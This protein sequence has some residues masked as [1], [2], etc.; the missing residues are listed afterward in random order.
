MADDFTLLPYARP[1]LV[2]STRLGGAD[3]RLTLR[4]DAEVLADGQVDGSAVNL[5]AALKGPGDVVGF[6]SRAIS[7]SDPDARS[8]EFEANYLPY[9]EFAEVDFPWRYSLDK[10]ATGG[11]V[12]PWL[13]LIALKADE[14]EVLEPDDNAPLPAIRVGSATDSLPPLDQLV[15]TCHV[16][17]ARDEGETD[18]SALLASEPEQARAR[19][20]CV[21]N[22]EEAAVYT[23]FL[24]PSYE[25]GRQAGLGL[26]PTAT[27]P[28]LPAWERND[29][30]IDLPV[31]YSRRFV[32]NSGEDIEAMLR[33]LRSINSADAEGIGD[34]PRIFAGAPGHYDD[35]SHQTAGFLRQAA[36]QEPGTP[37]PGFD[38]DLRLVQRIDD[39][40]TEAIEGDVQDNG[41]DPLVTFPAYG[42]RYRHDTTLNSVNRTGYWFDHLNLDLK[43]RDAA[44]R[45]AIIVRR[46]QDR[47]MRLAWEQYEGIV[48]ANRRLARLQ[49]AQKLVERMSKRRLDHLETGTL[50]SLAEPLW[51][52]VQTNK[53]DTSLRKGITARGAPDSYVS[54][55]MRRLAAKRSRAPER[56]S[57]MRATP[58]P[59]LPG[60]VD[61]AEAARAS[62]T[63]AHRRAAPEPIRIDAQT[64]D[65]LSALMGRDY[66]SEKVTLTGAIAVGAVSSKSLASPVTSLLAVLPEAKAA[67]LV[68]GRTRQEARTIAPVFRAPDIAD[69]L[70]ERQVEQDPSALFAGLERLPD[71]TVTFFE[72]NRAFIEAFMVGAN[73]E[74]ARELRWRGFPTDMR[75]TVFR[76]FWQRGYAPGDPAGDDINPIHK[77]AGPLGQNPCDAD[78]DQAEDLVMVM[79]GDIIRKIGVPI[80]EINI[81]NGTSW[82]AGEGVSHSPNFFGRV[83]DAAYFGFDIARDFLTSAPV[84]E[85]AFM[86][87]YEPPGRMRFGL[88]IGERQVRLDRR[89]DS[90]IRHRFPV[91]GQALSHPASRILKT[92]PVMAPPAQPQ[93]WSDLS[94]SH[95]RQT[96]AGYLDFTDTVRPI[97]GPDHWS[98]AKTSA[99]VAISLWQKPVAAVLP[100]KRVL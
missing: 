38:T 66:L 2:T 54:R 6:D 57:D 11:R 49:A 89:D 52:I 61:R 15:H 92:G 29:V 68:G 32:T 95:V 48:E 34:P 69:A 47:Y 82:E 93:S 99:S 50:I 18:G 31:Y 3:Q 37:G 100:L 74:M 25:L 28:T 88:D 79:K 4:F 36:T 83:G 17:V 1:G 16:H 9:L 22:L 64:E 94:W 41:E 62:R 46:H 8:G 78:R 81:A 97:T 59:G 14:Y 55:S 19:L 77:W 84:A 26:A 90:L 23:L 63:Q 44:G 91:S 10:T 98:A 67:A 42:W 86:V 70:A 27:P 35:Y 80:I 96:G 60:D 45:G 75:G 21:R 65:A 53:S 85:R 72:E 30:N 7:A 33:R 39:T 5:S 40:L 87:I 24:V 51:D 43:F 56:G 76:R 58:A 71:N 13:A 12:K 20:L 73:H